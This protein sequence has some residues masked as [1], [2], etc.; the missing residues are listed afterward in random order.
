MGGAHLG[1]GMVRRPLRLASGACEEADKRLKT[2]IARA[3][4]LN[5]YSKPVFALPSL[6]TKSF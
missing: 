3:E 2:S 1:G 6:A 5:L 4:D